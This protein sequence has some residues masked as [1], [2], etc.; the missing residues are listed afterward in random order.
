M[1]SQSIFFSFSDLFHLPCR[2]IHVVKMTRFHFL[3]LNS[4]PSHTQ[5][6]TYPIF[7]H[8]STDRHL[9]A[10]ISWLLQIVLQWTWATY[11][12]FNLVSLYSSEME[13]LDLVVNV[14]SFN[15]FNNLHIF[16]MAASIYIPTSTAQQFPFL[17]IF[18]NTCCILILIIAILTGVWCYL[19]VV[20]I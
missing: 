9:C 6:H 11:I 10:S 1:K 7:I 3:W 19:S 2:S 4:I 18:T 8:S 15:F 13:M 5:T 17:H 12:F 16:I 20:L 14:S